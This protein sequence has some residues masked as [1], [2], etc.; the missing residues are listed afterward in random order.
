M[1]VRNP[2]CN[3][4]S[5]YVDETMTTKKD[6]SCIFNLEPIKV[7]GPGI[8]NTGYFCDRFDDRGDIHNSRMFAGII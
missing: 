6:I 8:N 2:L 7:D 5:E 1:C 3:M 4:C